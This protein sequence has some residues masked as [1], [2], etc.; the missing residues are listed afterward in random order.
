M[1]MAHTWDGVFELLWSVFIRVFRGDGGIFLNRY[2]SLLQ[3]LWLLWPCTSSMM[4]AWMQ[5]ARVDAVGVGKIVGLLAVLFFLLLDC[6]VE[7]VYFH[8]RVFVQVHS[9]VCRYFW[10][11]SWFA[12]SFFSFFSFFC[13]APFVGLLE[14]SMTSA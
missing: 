11:P 2:F 5:C 14:S 10:T 4:T 6:F 9:F 8:H 3:R 7:Y 13:F 1:V 12:T